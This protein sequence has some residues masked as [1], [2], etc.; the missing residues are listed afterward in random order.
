MDDQRRC[1]SVGPAAHGGD[2][3]GHLVYDHRDAQSALGQPP[4]P[5]FGIGNALRPPEL[6]LLDEVHTYEGRHGAQVAYS[7]A[8]G[9]ICCGSRYAL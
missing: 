4:Q 6:V 7:C 1:L 5:A 9:N 2:A 8:A 3:T